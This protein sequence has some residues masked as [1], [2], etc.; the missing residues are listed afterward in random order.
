[1]THS[2]LRLALASLALAATATPLSAQLLIDPDLP[3]PVV[4]PASEVS[5]YGFQAN[6]ETV[7]VADG[8]TVQTFV[9]NRA[10]ADGDVFYLFD[11]DF[12]Y[13]NNGRTMEDPDLNGTDAQKYVMG[14]FDDIHRLGWQM[15][16]QIYA[17]GMLGFNNYW[18]GYG[19]Q[20]QLMSPQWDL[21]KGG[22]TVYVTLT[23]CGDPGAKTCVVS[24]KDPNPIPNT[25]IDSK[26][27]PV[28]TEWATHTV[29]LKGGI[30]NGYIYLNFG[31]SGNMKSRLC[32]FIDDLKVYQ[33]FKAGEECDV[34]WGYN[35]CPGTDTNW[36]YVETDQTEK[37]QYAYGVTIYKSGANSLLSDFAYIEQ[38]TGISTPADAADSG[39]KVSGQALYLGATGLQPVS[40]YT[41]AGELV[42]ACQAGQWRDGLRLPE[43]G[44]YLVRVGNRTTKVVVK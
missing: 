25:T 42:Y 22:G 19:N 18:K 37:G 3:V 24:L 14:N 16:D 33:K 10:K 12:S 6:W 29:E 11:S 2:T 39:V 17:D 38:S 28:T 34:W 30:S 13:I 41:A 36:E 5:E 20:G 23:I 40:I 8:Y 7:P 35:V 15:A 4:L 31:E 27:V 1:M 26:T 44:T 43:A 21:S 32:Y 9:T